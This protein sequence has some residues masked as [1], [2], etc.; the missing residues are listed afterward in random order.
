MEEVADHLFEAFC[1]TLPPNSAA[2]RE[3]K[4]KSA[5][6]QREMVRKRLDAFFATAREE[7]ERRRLGVIG[8]AR[9]AYALQKRMLE[10]GYPRHLTKQILLALVMSAFVRARV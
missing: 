1:K 2:M 10:A 9:V 4:R 3:Y 8:R 7:Q 5:D 6:D